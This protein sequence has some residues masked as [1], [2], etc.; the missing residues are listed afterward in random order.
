MGMLNAAPLSP[1]LLYQPGHLLPHSQPLPSERSSCSARTA[2]GFVP[3]GKRDIY[4]THIC[5]RASMPCSS[6]STNQ[7]QSH[8]LTLLGVCG[9]HTH[10][11]R[12]K[13]QSNGSVLHAINSNLKRHI[14]SCHALTPNVQRPMQSNKPRHADSSAVRKAQLRAD[15]N[16]LPLPI[17]H[18]GSLCEHN[19]NALYAG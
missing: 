15:A 5:L 8:S 9:R 18:Q 16:M 14:K 11:H 19:V 7:R 1:C 2:E 12:L 4:Q 6:R 3:G 17:A 10:D 13:C